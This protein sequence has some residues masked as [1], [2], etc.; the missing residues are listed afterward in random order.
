MEE[1]TI[2]SEEQVK[3]TQKWKQFLDDG[4]IT[5]N[6]LTK[7]KRLEIFTPNHPEGSL[8]EIEKSLAVSVQYSQKMTKL[9]FFLTKGFVPQQD[10]WSAWKTKVGVFVYFQKDIYDNLKNQDCPCLKNILKDVGRTFVGQ[11]YFK[12]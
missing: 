11:K 4:Q 7:Q 6:K 3:G 5:L 2:K 8:S 9:D 1:G 12:V 10:R